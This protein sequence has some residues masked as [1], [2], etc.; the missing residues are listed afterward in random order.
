[1]VE[2][3]TGRTNECRAGG[4][5]QGDVS[6]IIPAYNEESVIA[7]T[8]GAVH[9]SLRDR[10]GYEIIVADHGSDDDTRLLAKREGARVIEAPDA[11]T[12]GALR[13]LAVERARG[14]LLVFLDADI[15]VTSAWG[16]RLT[17]ILPCVGPGSRTLTGSIALPLPD[18]S[19]IE[20]YW[21]S[22]RVPA[23]THLGSGH[24]IIR[25][26]FFHELGG[27][28]PSLRTGEDY[29]LS[30]RVVSAGGDIVVDQSLA[31]T[32][33]GFPKTVVEF[34]RREA[35]HGLSDFGSISKVRAS[36]VALATLGWLGLHVLFAVGLISG[37]G[38]LAVFAIVSTGTLC[39]VSSA[40]R[41][42]NRSL[43][44]WIIA[45]SLF[46][47]YYLG[48]ALSFFRSI[49]HLDRGNPRKAIQPNS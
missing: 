18:S 36:R 31:V 32:H 38:V 7:E 4:G 5:I 25:S 46:Y 22:R 42:E 2:L 15:I 43:R 17:K 27:F 8:L 34:V 9:A 47:L 33:L 37:I 39:G 11:P 48:R 12:I 19:W 16:V 26:D 28:D 44:E 20:N 24:M 40:L 23:G 3:Q 10:L 1:V 49:L 14:Q 21:F 35:W 13:N 6:V 45:T 30:R 29:D 41:F